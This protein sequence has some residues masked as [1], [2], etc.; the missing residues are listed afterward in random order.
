[1]V[2]IG[3]GVVVRVSSFDMDPLGIT[4]RQGRL[5]LSLPNIKIILKIE[6]FYGHVGEDQPSSRGSFSLERSGQ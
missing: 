3:P 6:R 2:E 1:M 5:Q 4:Y